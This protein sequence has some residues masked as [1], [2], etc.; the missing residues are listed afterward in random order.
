MSVG[1]DSAEKESDAAHPAYTVF[2]FNAPLI[3]SFQY[4]LL[5]VFKSAY[6]FPV[7]K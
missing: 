4:V 7:A 3:N 2:I 6:R 5:A 1:P